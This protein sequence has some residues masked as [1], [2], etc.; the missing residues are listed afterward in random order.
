MRIITSALTHQRCAINKGL[1]IVP[2]TSEVYV[3]D[4]VILTLSEFLLLL[5]IPDKMD[6]STNTTFY[7]FVN[8]PRKI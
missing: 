7:L 3:S 1:E 4:G 6:I 2:G 5:H 8:R